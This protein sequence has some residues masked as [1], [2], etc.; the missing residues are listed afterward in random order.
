[1]ERSGNPGHPRQWYQTPFPLSVH[2]NRAISARRDI[3][4]H[5]YVTWQYYFDIFGLDAHP[6]LALIAERKVSHSYESCIRS[7]SRFNFVSFFRCIQ[8]L[9]KGSFPRLVNCSSFLYPG[10]FFDTQSGYALLS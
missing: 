7:T 1:V 9:W 4:L 6:G 5:L 2:H 8:P 3:V 10:N